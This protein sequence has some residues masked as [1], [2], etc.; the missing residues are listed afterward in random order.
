MRELVSVVVPVYNVEDY[1]DDCVESI[2]AQ[3]YAELEIILVDDGSADGSGSLCD[4]WAARDGRIRVIHQENRGLG[5]ARNRGLELARGTYVFF[6]DSDDSVENTLVEKCLDRARCHDAQV[7][8]YGCSRVQGNRITPTP[9]RPGKTVYRDEEVQAQLLPGLFTYDLGLGISAWGKMYKLDF[10]RL[11]GL[12]FPSE[13]EIIS[14]DGW[15][16]LE[17]FSKVSC[18]AVL[19]ECL[20]RY[21]CRS[22]SLTRGFRPDRQQKNDDFLLKSQAF[23]EELGLPDLVRNHLRSR[24]HGLTLG[25]MMQLTAS[26]L[27]RR[28]KRKALHA[29]YRS[30][31]LQETLTEDVLMLDGKMP[32]VFWRCLRS[33]CYGLCTLLLHLNRIR[34][35]GRDS[36]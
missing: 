26:P 6:W 20:Y 13:R 25:A 23:S 8:L 4:Q 7:V 30:P 28:E 3:T 16:A 31:V 19:P 27:S 18:A 22:G 10:L 11:Q 2:L 33:R 35:A 12:S 9:V 24:Y 29:I 1:L 5:M 14:E 21:R 15:F 34:R 17:L 36:R 32:R